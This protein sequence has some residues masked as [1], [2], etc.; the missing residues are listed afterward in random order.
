MHSTVNEPK[1]TQRFPDALICNYY[2]YLSVAILVVGVLSVVAHGYIMFSIPS[3]YKV[4]VIMSLLL[5][6]I[7]L[8][9]VYYIYLFAYLLCS[10]TLLDKKSNQVA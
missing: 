4:P 10:R 9:I 6:V 1:W 5:S 3:K 7:Q 8:G 2:F